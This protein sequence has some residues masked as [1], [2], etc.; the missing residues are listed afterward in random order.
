MDKSA[1]IYIAGHT[2]LAGSAIKRLLIE[3]GYTNMLVAKSNELDLTRQ[4]DVENF[5]EKNKPEYVFVCAAKAGGIRANMDHPASFYYINSMIANNILHTSYLY[6]VKK[7]LYLG[8][9][10]IYPRHAHQPIIE[11]ELLTG[12][13]EPTNEGYAI[14]KIAGLKM[15]EYYRDQY[16]VNF[17]SAMPTNLY[18]IND[19]FNLNEGHLIPNLIRKFHEA[20]IHHNKKVVVWGTGKVYRELLY[21]DDLAEALIFLMLNYNSRGHINIGTG[22]DHTISEY[23]EMV[24][25]VVGYTGSIVYDHTQPDGIPRKKL[26]VSKINEM[27]WH[28]KT[29][30]EDG[31]K[32]VYE[33]YKKKYSVLSLS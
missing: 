9:S 26:N 3:E 8:S 15:C 16:G 32:I 28:A 7:L 12:K 25:K 2:G 20:K 17:I 24:K 22:E 31:L 5:F 1:K 6:G 18:G 13:L 4:V 11:D 30:L 21:V 10:C 14:A 29:K 19:N 27:G 23:A 33:W